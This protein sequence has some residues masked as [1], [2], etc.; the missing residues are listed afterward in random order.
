MKACEDLLKY[1][2]CVM[3]SRPTCNEKELKNHLL[4]F[5]HTDD[6]SQLLEV[7]KIIGGKYNLIGE[8]DIIKV[9]YAIKELNNCIVTL[10]NHIS[11]I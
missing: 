11:Q 5:M 3:E 6:P 4:L 2:H 9:Y 10:R 1:F 7:N 8:E